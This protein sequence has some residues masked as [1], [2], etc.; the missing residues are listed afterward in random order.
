MHSHRCKYCALQ[1]VSTVWHHDDSKRGDLSAHTCPRCGKQEWEQYQ[2]VSGG[3]P[4]GGVQFGHAGHASPWPF[5][6]K[7][8]GALRIGAGVLLLGVAV[9]LFVRAIQLARGGNAE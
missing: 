9:I 6:D 4:V 7:I 8:E 2:H 3:L 1:G 5:G